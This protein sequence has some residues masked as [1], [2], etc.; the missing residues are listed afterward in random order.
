MN[1]KLRDIDLEANRQAI[2]QIRGELATVGEISE[3]IG[4]LPPVET[5]QSMFSTEI[6]QLLAR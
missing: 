1:R 2:E 4:S 3:W 6:V 5:V